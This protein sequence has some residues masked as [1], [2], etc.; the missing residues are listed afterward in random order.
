MSTM[1][2]VCT[3]EK[4]CDAMDISDLVSGSCSCD[5]DT[6]GKVCCTELLLDLKVMGVGLDIC[7]AKLKSMLDALPADAKTAADAE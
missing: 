2:P 5:D 6:S 7:S 3:K 1:D 4:F